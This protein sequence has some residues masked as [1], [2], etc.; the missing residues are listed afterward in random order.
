MHP[1]FSFRLAEKTASA[2]ACRRP[3]AACGG[4]WAGD[5]RAVHGPKEKAL[6]AKPRAESARFGKCGGRVNRCGGCR[7][8]RL[9]CALLRWSKDPWAVQT[10]RRADGVQNRICPG[11]SFRTFR[12]ARC[13]PGGCG[14]RRR[15]TRVPPYHR[16]GRGARR[17]RVFR[18]FRRGRFHIGPPPGAPLAPGERQRKETLVNSLTTHVPPPQLLCGDQALQVP[19]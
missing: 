4:S 9:P 15:D 7:Q 10:V 13:C 11:F 6:G 3:T 5:K 12:F 19:W 1:P 2:G 8:P 17:C 14:Q 18:A 16:P